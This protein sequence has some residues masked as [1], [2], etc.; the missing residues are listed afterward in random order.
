M[1]IIGVAVACALVISAICIRNLNVSVRDAQRDAVIMASNVSKAFIDQKWK[2]AELVSRWT[3]ED[4][5]IIEAL[6]ALKASQGDAERQ[7]LVEAASRIASIGLV[8]FMTITDENGVVVA[9]THSAET[10]D[11]VSATPS[12]K[13]ALGGSRF[14]TIEPDATVKMSLCSGSPVYRGGNLIG[15]LATGFRF[16]NS[17]FVDRMKEISQAEVSILMGDTRVSTTIVNDKGERYA[18]AKTAERISKSVLAGNDYIGNATVAG[19]KMYTIYTPLRNAEGAVIGM[20]FEGLETSAFEAQ[21]HK[22]VAG[23]IAVTLVLGAVTVLAARKIANSIAK[24]IADNYNYGGHKAC[25][26]YDY[27]EHKACDYYDYGGHPAPDGASPTQPF[28]AVKM[29]KSKSTSTPMRFWF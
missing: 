20:L 24:H 4:H 10:G 14:T 23:I 26:Y 11:N 27:G 19:K 16:D 18:G 3:A 6:A 5:D 12:I 1:P 2:D 17:N 15:A 13:A 29:L 28:N 9:R 8:D 21:L 22:M 7:R 25:N